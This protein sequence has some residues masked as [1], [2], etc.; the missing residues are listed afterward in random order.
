MTVFGRIVGD[1]GR[2]IFLQAVGSERI[3]MEYTA[4]RLEEGTDSGLEEGTASRLE[5]GT[6]SKL[7]LTVGTFSTIGEDWGWRP[8]WP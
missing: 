7:E 8:T 6:A 2:E 3:W 5:E 1:A 4:L